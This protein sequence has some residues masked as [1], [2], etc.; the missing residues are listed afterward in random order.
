MN[1]EKSKGKNPAHVIRADARWEK[2]AF[3]DYRKKMNGLLAKDRAPAGSA[4]ADKRENPIAC[5][6]AIRY[7]AAAGGF[8]TRAARLRP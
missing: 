1:V 7:D 4:I 5:W 2:V 8:A 3:D 6:P